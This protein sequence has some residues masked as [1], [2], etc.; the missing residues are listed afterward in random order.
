MFSTG[1]ELKCAAVQ[2]TLYAV[3]ECAHCK[4]CT[5][6]AHCKHCRYCTRMKHAQN[7]HLTSRLFHKAVTR[8]RASALDKSHPAYSVPL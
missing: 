8:G 2:Q 6:M 1:T 7:V 5:R 4:H 3:R